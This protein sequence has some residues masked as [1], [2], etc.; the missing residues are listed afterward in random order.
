MEINALMNT[1]DQSSEI[2]QHITFKRGLIIIQQVVHT[3][4]IDLHCCNEI[5]YKLDLAKGTMG[6][7]KIIFMRRVRYLDKMCLT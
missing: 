2:I 5:T 4:F 7:S 6:A 1:I 3:P